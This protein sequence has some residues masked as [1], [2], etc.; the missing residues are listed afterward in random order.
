MYVS[1]YGE[2]QCV[3]RVCANTSMCV[4]IGKDAVCGGYVNTVYGIVLSSSVYVRVCVRAYASRSMCACIYAA[5]AARA[6][7]YLNG[8][9][10][11]C[12]K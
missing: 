12:M 6:P 4:R 3:S 5:G 10:C 2:S 8:C 11:H 9:V 7:C 1:I